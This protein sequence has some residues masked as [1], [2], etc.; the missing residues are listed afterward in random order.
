M[1]ACCVTFIQTARDRWPPATVRCAAPDAT[2]SH[3]GQSERMDAG[4]ARVESRTADDALAVPAAGTPD[5]TVALEPLASASRRDRR[6]RRH[7]LVADILAGALAGAVTA[8]FAGL[9]AA[10]VPLVALAV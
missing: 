7:L 3:I 4:G 5:A 9:P 1:F 2:K 8:L 10:D 6:L